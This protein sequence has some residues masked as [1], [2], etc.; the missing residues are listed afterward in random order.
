MVLGNISRLFSNEDTEEPFESVDGRLSAEEQLLHQLSGQGELVCEASDGTTETRGAPESTVFA[1]FTDRTVLL[2]TEHGDV[3]EL[4]TV[5]YADI[6]H[7]RRT[8]GVLD[9][10]LEVRVWGEGT[11]RMPVGN[12]RKLSAAVEYANEAKEYWER[13]ESLLTNAEKANTQVERHITAG[14]LR[15][16]FEARDK[17]GTKLEQAR[18]VLTE[19]DIETAGL[20]QRIRAVELERYHSEVRARLRRATQLVADG[21]QQTERAEYD[22]AYE[23]YWRARD[24]LENAL[25]IVRRTE[26]EEPPTA[27]SEIARIENHLEHLEVR[28]IGLAKQAHDRAR[29]T[30]DPEQAVVAWTEAFEHYRDALEAG[31][32]TSLTFR[33]DTETIRGMLIRVL[34][35]LVEAHCWLAGELERAGDEYAD[36]GEY[37]RAK[38]QYK[39]ARDSYDDAL[40]FTWEFRVGDEQALRTER[41][42]LNAKYESVRWKLEQ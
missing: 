4:V 33:G 1:V 40:E 2:G 16:A 37:E 9:S 28:P 18:G 25:A 36:S 38:D 11:Y 22:G 35:N 14:N 5:Q 30:T 41:H 17:A 8:G 29:T 39:A 7:V 34:R 31:W 26:L 15:D 27:R 3:D 20:Q 24:H 32:G 21:E 6:K 12:R 23:S 42:R 10:T 13:V 19:T